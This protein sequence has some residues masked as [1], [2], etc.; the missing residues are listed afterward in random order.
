MEG[1]KPARQGTS[2]RLRA[3][4]SEFSSPEAR[5]ERLDAARRWEA[6]RTTPDRPAAIA[7]A[8]DTAPQPH[9]HDHL[10]PP[11]DVSGRQRLRVAGQEYY[12]EATQRLGG[13][14]LEPRYFTALLRREPTNPHD[15]NAIV[16]LVE[17][18][19]VGYVGRGRA[20]RWAAGLDRTGGVVTC[21]LQAFRGATRTWKMTLLADPRALDELKRAG[22]R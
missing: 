1:S 14:G 18:V 10:A 4:L 16:V 15:A 5:R 22:G 9:R 11:P 7:P 13:T 6:E 2:A 3:E 12:R 20:A 8:V 19:K 21:R 17:G